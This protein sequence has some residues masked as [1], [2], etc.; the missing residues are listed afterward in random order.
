[1]L[2]RKEIGDIYNALISQVDNALRQYRRNIGKILSYPTKKG[3]IDV[4]IGR[5]APT[6]IWHY[7]ENTPV[8]RRGKKP[9]TRISR[10]ARDVLNVLKKAQRLMTMRELSTLTGINARE[11]IAELRAKGVE[12]C[13]F[14]TR[15]GGYGL[16]GKSFVKQAELYRFVA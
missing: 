12:I 9:T 8:K 16:P 11:A 4:S 13:S 2:H 15:K 1:M 14:P 3:G 6:H 7:E 10:G 5:P